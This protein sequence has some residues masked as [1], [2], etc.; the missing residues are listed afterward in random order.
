MRRAA[1]GDPRRRSR[2]RCACSTS[3]R[4]R[5]EPIALGVGPFPESETR[6]T[7]RSCEVGTGTPRL[8]G[9]VSVT[10]RCCGSCCRRGRW[11]GRRWSCSR[12]PTWPSCARHRSPTGR[13]S[14]TRASTMCASCAPRR[15]PIYVAEGLFDVGITGRDWVEETASNVVTLGELRY[16]KATADPIKLVVAV[17]DDSPVTSVKELPGG[18]AG[19]DRVPRADPPLLRRSRHRRRRAPELRRQRGQGARHRRLR[20]RDHRDRDG[21]C[22]PPDCASS[23]PSSSATP[24]SSPTPGATPTR[25]SATPWAS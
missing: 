14:T 1:R 23:T 7:P 5:T 16:S 4:R 25:T 18:R 3:S 8:G 20:G 17:A 22:A 21:P 6:A 11:S 15:S 2:T 19:V 24:R 10:V 9:G 13:R 12:P